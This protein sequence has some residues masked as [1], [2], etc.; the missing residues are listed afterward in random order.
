MV[1]YSLGNKKQTA[2]RFSLNS[3]FALYFKEENR[4]LRPK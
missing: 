1:P 2:T 4:F 3:Y